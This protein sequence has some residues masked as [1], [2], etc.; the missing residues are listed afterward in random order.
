MPTRS[1][2]TNDFICGAILRCSSEARTGHEL[3]MTGHDVD[4]LADDGLDIGDIARDGL[5][6]LDTAAKPWRVLQRHAR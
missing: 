6:A 1:G 3:G 4:A 2:A 5:V